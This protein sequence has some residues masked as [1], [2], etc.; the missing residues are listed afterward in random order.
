MSGR[1]EAPWPRRDCSALLLAAGNGSRMGRGPKWRLMAGGR[2]LLEAALQQL[3]GLAAEILVGL[4]PEEVA[5][6][7]PIC[8]RF[9]ARAMAGGATRQET[10]ER[11]AVRSG[12]E[13]IVLHEIARPAASAALFRRVIE[14][15]AADGAAAPCLALPPRDSVGFVAAGRIERVLDRDALVHLQT[16]QAY[17]RGWL[18]QALAEARAD[19]LDS[20]T[21]VEIMLRAGHPVTAVPGEETNLKLTYPEDWPA[22]LAQR[23]FI[24]G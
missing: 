19:G 6:A 10:V 22:F 17:R 16:P 20:A 1:Q 4:P 3:A 8:A 21:A 7:E 15:A 9:G 5:A 24:P 13:L 2:T 11:L 14:A 23:E 18:L 12:R